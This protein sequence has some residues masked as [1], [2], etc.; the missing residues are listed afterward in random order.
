MIK[1]LKTFFITS[2][3]LVTTY[4]IAQRVSGGAPKPRASF[5]YE[6]MRAVANSLTVQRILN[7]TF[8][9][10]PFVIKNFELIGL[11]EEGYHY[12]LQTHSS[13]TDSECVLD[14]T[15]WNTHHALVS[16]I[17]VVD[18][19][20]ISGC[21]STKAAQL[22]P[23]VELISIAESKKVMDLL[24]F[25]FST[26]K[27]EL[28]KTDFEG[29]RY[30]VTARTVNGRTN[31]CEFDITVKNLEVTMTSMKEPCVIIEPPRL[32]STHEKYKGF[33][34][35]HP[36][37]MND[38]NLYETEYIS[39]AR[40]LSV[41]KRKEIRDYM[42]LADPKYYAVYSLHAKEMADKVKKSPD[43]KVGNA[44][45]ML[46]KVMGFPTDT[47]GI[48]APAIIGLSYAP[49]FILDADKL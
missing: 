34:N 26:E 29:S 36:T 38:E 47:G 44:L 20:I 41:E 13:V 5:G 27:L 4:A 25:N 19:K 14:A 46:Y 33:F 31:A 40:K 2:A 1:L 9:T 17:R 39:F 18:T 30:H 11:D 49:F 10:D 35:Q 15:V 23:L 6:N 22:N 37:P 48:Y 8:G 7:L 21:E 42:K 12:R 45:F 28:I 24:G 43:F 3:L 32:E 16:E